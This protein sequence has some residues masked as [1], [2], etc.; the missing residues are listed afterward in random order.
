MSISAVICVYNEE[1]RIES[2]LNCIAWC[3]EI[4]IVDRNSTDLTVELAK[5]YTDKIFILKKISYD[6]QDNEIWL[7]EV[8]SEWVLAVT[9]SDLIHPRLASQIRSMVDDPN[10]AF[11][12]I[13]IPYRRYVL[14][15]ETA[16]SPWYSSLS[17]GIVFRKCIARIK[18]DIVHGAIHFDTLRHFKM[19]ESTDYCMYHLTHASVDIMM[20]RHLNYCRAEGRLFP[21]E[22]SLW[23]A[24]KA[25]FRSAYDVI[26]KRKSYL[27]GWDGVALGIAYISYYMLRFVYI[28]ECRSSKAPETYAQIRETISQAWTATEKRKDNE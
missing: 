2:T 12:L 15:L 28:W 23:K 24:S 26:F 9:A 10:F 14:G 5:K 8:N 4:I 22:L 3:D 19:P 11:D 6:P 16:R 7:R 17:S 21:K 1:D 25:I 27:M 13:D 20:D 18:Q